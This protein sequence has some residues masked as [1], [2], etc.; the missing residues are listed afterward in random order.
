MCC[1]SKLILGALV[2]TVLA[3]SAAIVP[4]NA[5]DKISWRLQTVAAP[6]SLEF[7]ELPLAFAKRVGEASKG[8]LDI[9]VFASGVIA[10]EFEAGDAVGKG[11]L[12][13][14]HSYLTL[15]AGREPAF[16]TS[17]EWP[18][19]VHPLQGPMWYHKEAF[20]NFRKIAEKHGMYFLGVSPLLGEH[21]WSTK[22]LRS[23]EDLKGLKIRSGGL[24]ADS[25]ALLGASPVALPPT[26]I[27]SALQRKLVEAA[28][29][30]T[31]PVNYGFGLHE[32]AKYI[33]MPTYSGGANSDWV[34]NLKAWNALSPDLKAIVESAMNEVSYTYWLKSIQE[35]QKVMVELKSKGIEFVQWPPEEMRKLE[36]ARLRVMKEKYAP[37]SPALAEIVASQINFMKS[38]GYDVP[39]EFLE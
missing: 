26:E 16:K 25:F 31:L 12:Q 29:F 10:K 22:P 37:S 15:F 11:A 19:M 32:V 3:L 33:V 2:S 24:A 28:E 5:Q 6:N 39:K 9:K 35:E 30:T 4:A 34:V 23:V 17:S 36:I 38:L 18:V 21:I 14:W 20:G 7:N 1:L 8:R 13:M 27:Y